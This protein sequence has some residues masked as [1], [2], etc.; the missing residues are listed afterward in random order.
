MV[1]EKKNFVV[2]NTKKD[3]NKL[4]SNFYQEKWLSGLKR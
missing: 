4:L 2:K 3:S 1:V